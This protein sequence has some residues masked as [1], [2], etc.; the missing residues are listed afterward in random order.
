[1]VL[2][3]RIWLKRLTG[4]GDYPDRLNAI[5]YD[6]RAELTRAR[7]AEDNRLIAVIEQYDDAAL[8]SLIVT[9]NV[10]DAADSGSR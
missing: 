10:R 1:M 4:E 2:T 6:D 3:D 5:L 8:A 7:I 9:K